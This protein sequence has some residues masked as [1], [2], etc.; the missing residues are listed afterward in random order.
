MLAT[1]ENGNYLDQLARA[2]H[3]EDVSYHSIITEENIL[4]YGWE[5]IKKDWGHI[6]GKDFSNTDLANLLLDLARNGLGKLDKIADQ[7]TAMKFRGDGVVS[8]HSQNMNNIHA[9][10]HN[11]ALNARITHLKAEH[12]SSEMK[13]AILDAL[14]P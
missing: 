8:K 5:E 4:T 11:E 10:Q 12:G 2:N 7:F 6:R 14:Y 9:F 1:P 13:G 3:P